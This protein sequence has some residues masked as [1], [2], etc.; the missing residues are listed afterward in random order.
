[1]SA[2]TWDLTALANAADPRADAP[3]QHLWLARLLE[4]LRHVPRRAPAGRR[5]PIEGAD[6]GAAADD[7]ADAG[8]G[9]AAT[10]WP[11]RRLRHLV[12][13]M[14]Q[15]AAMGER[16]Q[17]VLAASLRRMDLAALFADFGFAERPTLGGELLER[18]QSRWLPAT[19]DTSDGATLFA[20]WLQP[21]DADW[22]RAIDD[23]TLQRL[24][25]LL[26]AVDVRDALLDAVTTLGSHLHSAGHGAGLRRRMD[27]AL[28][29]DNPFRA[30]PREIDDLREAL[31]A[32]P[33]AGGLA[34]P[35][36]AGGPPPPASRLAD[37]LQ[38]A[39]RLRAR[40]QACR[41]AAD[42]VT[43]HLEAH[44]VSVAIV[45][46]QELIRLRCD[47]IEL[48]LDVLLGDG[49][50]HEWRRLIVALLGTLRER[51]GIRPLLGQH[52]ALLARRVADRN[53]ETGEHYITRDRAE[54]RSMLGRAAGG[55]IV[56]AG[57][58]L[59][60][61]AIAAIGLSAFWTGFWSGVNYAL[62]F[63]VVMLLHWTVA[64]KQPAMTAP[65]LAASLPRGETAGEDEIEAFVD[66]V[67][68]LI[69]SQAAGIFGNVITCVPTV[70]AIVLALQ[71]LGPT[72]LGIAPVAPAKAQAV[73]DGLS[74]LGPTALFAAF[75]GVLLFLSSLIAG[76]VE[77]WFVLHRLDSALALNPRSVAVL[78]ASRARRV[79]S[80][81]RR[82]VSGV[83]ANVSLGMML[84]LV[85][86]LL[87]FFGLPLDVR[88]VTLAS[89]QVA[90]ATATLGADV[91]AMPALWWAVGGVAVTGLLNVAVSFWLAFRVA[92][93]SRGVRLNERARIN[94]AIRRRMRQRPGQF[95][96]P[97][98][99]GSG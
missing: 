44:G 62:S 11:V 18:L 25:A 46:A 24:A 28:Q 29:R 63:L 67:A 15:H 35:T 97:P 16:M 31:E 2:P 82:N 47:R 57:A 22:L 20:M 85:P 92:M 60:K 81:W 88:H 89:G 4:W 79:G 6:A 83:A 84:G 70:L 42:T 94:A 49:R 53:A 12:N 95:L 33:P 87:G 5:G 73:L 54:Y 99:E 30:L 48:L 93:R 9:G 17:G 38:A 78:G 43:A 1:M 69:R 32:A 51:R 66:R 98:R 80:W 76:A 75:T 37:T 52:Y 27:A 19:P 71:W 64:T 7:G 3:A 40:L 13:Q 96:F 34:A 55:G 10:P 77:N 50:A 41:A 86:A 72:V 90:A 36:H 23:D 26:P 39:N 68:Q 61:F 56:I 59:V 74:L 58:T 8:A 91:L 21:E 14:T 65:A 45:H